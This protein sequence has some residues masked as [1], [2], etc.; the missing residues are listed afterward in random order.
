MLDVLE[1]EQSTIG[2]IVLLRHL[3]RMAGYRILG[4]HIGRIVLDFRP[5]FA[6]QV[7]AQR[8]HDTTARCA[9]Q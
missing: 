9:R 1:Q 6:R 3:D 2:E 7:I 8:G 5:V 4:E